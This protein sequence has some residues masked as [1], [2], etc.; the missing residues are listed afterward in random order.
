M[1]GYPTQGATRSL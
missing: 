1:L